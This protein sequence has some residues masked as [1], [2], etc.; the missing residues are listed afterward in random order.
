M[1]NTP[2]EMRDL[3]EFRRRVTGDVLI[4]G[5]GVRHR[6]A[7]RIAVAVIEISKTS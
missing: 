6:R 2:S 4:N 3:D 1:S 7:N 5:L